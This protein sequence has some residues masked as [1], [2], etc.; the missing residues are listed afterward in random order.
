MIHS[1]P[2]MALCQVYVPSGYDI[3]HVVLQNGPNKHTHKVKHT[4]EH[5]QRFTNTVKLNICRVI[6]S[7]Q[8]ENISAFIFLVLII[9]QF[10]VGITLLL[11][12]LLC[13]L[14]KEAEEVQESTGSSAS[15]LRLDDTNDFP[16]WVGK[17]SSLL[18]C[19]FR[20]QAVK[21]MTSYERQGSFTP[22]FHFMVITLILRRYLTYIKL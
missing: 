19:N 3:R 13:F 12:H 22:F 8:R 2:K 1:T 7:R 20:H 5:T 11:N 9:R 17:A 4:W 14:I 21:A 10:H 15:K 6:S 16:V 18:C